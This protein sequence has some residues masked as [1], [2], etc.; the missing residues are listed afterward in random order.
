MGGKLLP[1]PTWMRILAPVLTPIPGIAVRPWK[2][3]E[4]P[5][6]PRFSWRGVALVEDGL[7]RAGEAGDD[8]GGGVHAGDDDGL[9]VERGK[10]SS[11][12]RSAI[13]GA[14]GRS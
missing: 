11:T 12:R 8:Q 7:E 4:P 14:F 6:I 10:M 3:G 5:A 13:L 9:F 1:S 2:E